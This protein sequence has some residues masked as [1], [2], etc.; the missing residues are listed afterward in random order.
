MDELG[1]AGNVAVRLGGQ[2][3]LISSVWEFQFATDTNAKGVKDWKH[4]TKDIPTAQVKQTTYLG[5]SS[6]LPL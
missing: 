1:R 4:Q 5:L 2:E 6:C 3:E